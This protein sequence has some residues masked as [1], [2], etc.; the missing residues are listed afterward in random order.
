MT[1]KLA[2]LQ[3]LKLA[4]S[5]LGVSF[6]FKFTMAKSSASTPNTILQP[7]QKAVPSLTSPTKTAP[8]GQENIQT[9]DLCHVISEPV[10]LQQIQ[11]YVPYFA[12]PS[13]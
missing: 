5:M 8:L 10:I 9:E 12:G 6:K 3:Y 1:L 7:T 13:T 2:S 4:S 11:Y